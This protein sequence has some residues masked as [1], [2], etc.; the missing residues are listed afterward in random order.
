MMHQITERTI[1]MKILDNTEDTVLARG[2]ILD[3]VHNIAVE[4][5]IDINT[6]E[7]KNVEA[8]MVKVPFPECKP[9]LD[10][11]KKIIGFKLNA[12]ISQRLISAIGGSLGCIHLS[13]VVVETI[14]LAA[15]TIFGIKC[16]GK[17]WREGIISDEEFWNRVKPLLK[18]T[19]RVFQNDE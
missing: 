17:E 1:N 15:N 13:E 6:L 14:R 7:I 16:G 11:L 3:Q 5:I 9:A 12:G 4:M 18:G 10:N 19:C 2:S 8:Q